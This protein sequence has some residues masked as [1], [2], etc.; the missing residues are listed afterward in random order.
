MTAKKTI[1]MPITAEIGPW[2][3]CEAKTGPEWLILGE[4]APKMPYFDKNIA[5]TPKISDLLFLK[6]SSL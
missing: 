2:R 4:T 5:Y 6:L 3:I 1:P